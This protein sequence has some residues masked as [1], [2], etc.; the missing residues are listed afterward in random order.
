MRITRPD[1]ES[2]LVNDRIPKERGTVY[3][4]IPFGGGISF[5]LSGRRSVGG[6]VCSLTPETQRLLGKHWPPPDENTDARTTP[7]TPAALNPDHWLPLRP[8][9]LMTSGDSQ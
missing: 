2:S 3:D 4:K 1:A 7:P 5:R 6:S 8:G 9:F